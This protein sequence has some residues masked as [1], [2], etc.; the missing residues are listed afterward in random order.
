[1][2][3][4]DACR[5]LDHKLRKTA[6]ALQSWS[7]KNIGS[8]RSQ[9]FMARELIAQFD[10]AQEHRLLSN[11]EQTLRKQLKLISLGLASLARTIARQRSRLRFLEEGDANTKFFHLQACHRNRKNHIPSILHNGVWFS[12]DE[13]KSEVIYDYFNGILGTSFQ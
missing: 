13:A 7:I 3:G 8:V 5:V 11:N 1:M 9:L 12:S 10:A 6:K 2:P 4:A